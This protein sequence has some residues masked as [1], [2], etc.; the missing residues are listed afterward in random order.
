MTSY[1]SGP[2]TAR[3]LI[4]LRLYYAFITPIILRPPSDC[5]FLV[6]GL[7]SGS[8]FWLRKEPRNTYAR[9][10]N[11]PAT[12]RGT[13]AR[14]PRAGAKEWMRFPKFLVSEWVPQKYMVFL[15]VGPDFYIT[16]LLRQYYA[17]ITPTKTFQKHL[18]GV[19]SL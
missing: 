17:F 9:L 6:L 15:A 12:I 11:G 14:H 19:I 16:P 4:L 18:A 10:R 3:Y 2:Q 5:A 7:N 13:S 1:T 8:I